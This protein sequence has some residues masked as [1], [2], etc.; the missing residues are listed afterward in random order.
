MSTG[1]SRLVV[2]T[3]S[4]SGIV[5]DGYR[6]RKYGQ[7]NVKGNENPRYMVAFA[8]ELVHRHTNS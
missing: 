5:E 7:K 3:P 8:L 2:H 6:W 1:E 4:A